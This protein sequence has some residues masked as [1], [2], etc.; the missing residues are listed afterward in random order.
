M[1]VTKISVTFQ[2]VQVFDDPALWGPA[3]WFLNAQVD[4][5]P[6]GDPAHEFEVKA[7]S[8]VALPAAWTTD[9]DVST[10]AAGDTV[11]V[12]FAAHSTGASGD[13]DLGQC[14]LTLK[15]P[16]KDDI[17]ITLPGS[18]IRN[19]VLYNITI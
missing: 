6:V 8:T 18:K 7:R 9:V 1:A 16:F 14:S 13:I 3:S 4:G 15:Y 11:E 12:K 19:L 2:S 5:A 17:N 10:K